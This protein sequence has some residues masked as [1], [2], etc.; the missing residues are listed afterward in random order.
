A[1]LIV[2]WYLRGLTVTEPA[3]RPIL[4]R[5]LAF[6]AGILVIYTVL[7][8][9]FEYLA[10]HQFFFN[11]LQHVAMHHLGP[12]LIALAWP[13][14][15]IMRGMPPQLRRIVQHPISTATVSILQQPVLAGLLFVGLIFLWL[16]PSIHFAAMID[17]RLYSIMNW[18]M[19]VDGILFWFLV[20]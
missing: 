7:E 3:A 2:W 13:G 16:I 15:T 4:P 20:L 17:S 12:L 9:R 10:E 14:E 19:V 1:W 11:R 18:S 6:L 5:R 8:T